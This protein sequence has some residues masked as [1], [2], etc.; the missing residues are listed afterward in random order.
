MDNPLTRLPGEPDLERRPRVDAVALLG[1]DDN[2][3]AHQQLRAE[4]LWLPHGLGRLTDDTSSL[5]D[6]EARRIAWSLYR[7][8]PVPA[9]LTGT[10]EGIWASLAPPE[11]DL[12]SSD[13]RALVNFFAIGSNFHLRRQREHLDHW[14]VATRLINGDSLQGLKLPKK[15]RRTLQRAT[16]RSAGIARSTHGTVRRSC[17]GG[18]DTDSACT[19]FEDQGGYRARLAVQ[20]L[21]TLDSQ[22]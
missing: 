14:H 16:K 9:A 1:W 21:P 2:K 13:E 17:P 5:F 8:A 11:G 22:R 6:Q 7:D 4:S 19:T 10:I 20:G 12:L 3:P 18:R 15:Y